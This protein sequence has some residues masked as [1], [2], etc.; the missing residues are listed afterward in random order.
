MR[1]KK[2]IIIRKNNDFEIRLGYPFFHIDLIDNGEKN[3]VTVYGGGFWD[4]DFENKK[5][6]LFGTSSDFGK[7]FKRDILIAI[8]NMDNHKWWQFS[9]ICERIFGKEYPDIDF[10]NMEKEFKFNIQYD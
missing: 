9:W 7:P 1:Y 2:F 8:K 10:D 4:L 5:I 3:N 6:N